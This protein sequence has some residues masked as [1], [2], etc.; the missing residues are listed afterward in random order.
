M[1]RHHLFLHVTL[2]I[3]A[4]TV[5]TLGLIFAVPVLEFLLPVFQQLGFL[6]DLD[7]S[8]EV[9]RAALELRPL[10]SLYRATCL[11]NLANSLRDRFEQRGSL[12]DLDEA[13]K[14]YRAALLLRPPGNYDRASALANLADS[15]EDK[16]KQCGTLADL[17]EA[18]ELNL[19][20]LLLCPPGHSDRAMCLNNL[21]ISIHDRFDQRGALSDLDEAVELH[22][23]AL[24][25]RPPDHSERVVSLSN[26]ALGLRDRFKQ[27]GSLSDLD[28]AIELQ[29]AALLL[30]CP[31]HPKRASSF[32]NLAASLRDKFQQCGALSDLD[33]AIE[34]NRA[35]LLL[36]SPGHSERV[37]SLNNLANS[38][39]DR[40][41]Q[42]GSSS[43]LDEA[44][45]LYRAALL[46]CPSGHNDRSISL[47][48]LARSLIDRFNQRGTL[49]DLDDAIEH[50]R[51]ALLLCPPGHSLRSMSLNNL[52]ISLRNRFHQCGTLSDLDEAIELNQAALLLCPPGHSDRS[53]SLNNLATSLR[54]RFRRCGALSELDDA[55]EF[56]RAA[57]LLHPPG[58]S[59]RS[60][61]LN[62]LANSLYDRFHQHGALFELDDAIELHRAALLLRPPDSSTGMSYRTWMNHLG[63]IWN[64]PASLMQHLVAILML[65]KS[66]TALKFLDRH[67]ALLSSSLRHFDVFKEAT[68][69]LAM[70]A[71]SCSIRYGDLMTAVELVEQG[72]AVFWTHL[73]RFRTPIDEL[74]LSGDPG[75]TLAD[76]FKRL[77]FRL[78][79]S[80]QIRQL[81]MQWDDVVSRI[82]MLPDFSHFLLPP[83]FSGLQKAA[84]EGPVIV[85]NASQYSCDALIIFG[86][87][88]PVH[89]PLDIT[90]TEV[91]ELSSEFQ[92]LAEE[93]GSSD[94][95]QELASILREL[96]KLYLESKVEYG[97]RIW[98]CPTAEF[99]LL[100]LHAAGPYEKKKDNLPHIYISSYTPTLAA[101]IRARQQVSGDTSMQHFVAVGQANPDRGKALRC[102]APELAVVAQRLSPLVSF[103]SLE[104]SGATVQG[105]LDALRHNQWLHLACHGM[106]NRKQPFES[107]FAMR[108][109]P[110]MITDIIRSHWQNPEFA[111]LSACHTTV[112]DETS[113]DE[114]IHLAAAM[115]FSGFR[116]VIGSMWSVDDDVARQVVSA[117]YGNLVDGSGRL[118]CTR[119][120]VA[121]QKAVKSLRK[122]KIPLEQQI[123]FVHIAPGTIGYH[124]LVQHH[125]SCSHA[126]VTE[127]HGIVTLSDFAVRSTRC[128]LDIRKIY[129]S[130]PVAS[131]SDKE[132]GEILAFAE[133]MVAAGRTYC[134]LPWGEEYLL[135]VL[136]FH[137]KLGWQRQQACQCV[138]LNHIAPK[139]EDYLQGLCECQD[140]P[141]LRKT[142]MNTSQGILDGG[143]NASLF[144]G[145]SGTF[146]LPTDSSARHPCGK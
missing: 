108:D 94:H 41:E 50:H 96:W 53:M 29:R 42:R 82:R 91:S 116:S 71:F 35:A 79:Q 77:S 78:H 141:T 36:H 134:W 114:S 9:Y 27:R 18:I 5:P 119:A 25:L 130:V 16:F 133:K 68:S 28:E 1:L 17:D 22:R 74:S 30:L 124:S 52:A 56:N 51:A 39:R 65:P 127:S 120:A 81:T 32:T 80:P 131:G 128:G 3:R 106:P 2:I 6:S 144:G 72:R 67:V 115:Q 88:D 109:G 104:D 113:L 46:L 125:I 107:S 140:L 13:I 93:F 33:E 97:S 48:N 103:T 12:S 44:I 60:M 137:S 86:F 19:A 90:Q 37:V 143:L 58:H 23:A 10:G 126:N 110:L 4:A 70:D 8:I 64:S 87:R 57:L 75:A 99:T 139:I 102:V 85:V 38:L 31:G 43:D 55:I 132:W 89:I 136:S 34:L 117:F 135:K 123:V 15:L 40:F 100:P 49:S 62:N 105:A 76:E 145:I 59:D 95:Q 112:G 73:A 61:S 129:T 14:L 83:P 24:L 26:L 63:S 11:N 54:D 122:M 138:V 20:A 21:A 111:F 121:L 7:E 45:E 66:W 118:E 98:W 92:S 84:D 142:A 69:S 146:P 101:L 47:N